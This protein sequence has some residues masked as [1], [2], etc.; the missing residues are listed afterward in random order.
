MRS[1]TAEGSGKSKISFPKNPYGDYVQRPST[2]LNVMNNKR[3]ID[4]DVR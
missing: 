2:Q 3:R 4:W 1:E